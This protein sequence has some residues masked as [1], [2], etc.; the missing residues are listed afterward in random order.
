MGSLTLASIGYEQGTRDPSGSARRASAREASHGCYDR[1]PVMLDD[2]P[3]QLPLWSD[4]TAA[5]AWAVR[6]SRR[7]RRLAVRV[8]HTGR[9]EIVVPR[10]TSRRAIAQFLD[11]HRA[12]IETKLA[13]ARRRAA[14]PEPFPP[15]TIELAACGQSWRVHLAGGNG[16]LRARHC[17]RDPGPGWRCVRCTPRAPRLARLARGARTRRSRAC[18]GRMRAPSRL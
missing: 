12:W 10:R 13:R 15:R 5:E 11:G 2:A 17:A 4:D 16:A 3:P 7:A 14:A 6:E 18:A 1:R 9:V 8:F